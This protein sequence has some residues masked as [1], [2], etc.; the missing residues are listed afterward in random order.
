MHALVVHSVVGFDPAC[1]KLFI[2]TKDFREGSGDEHLIDVLLLPP[3][4]MAVDARGLPYLDVQ[5]NTVGVF[6]NLF[7]KAYTSHVV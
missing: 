7:S 2:S 4:C 1:P 3:P 5:R 6:Y